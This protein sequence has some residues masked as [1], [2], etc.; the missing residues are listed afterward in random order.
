MY[1]F[2]ITPDSNL[3]KNFISLQ[4]SLSAYILKIFGYNVFSISN[5]ISIDNGYEIK[6]ISG[7]NFIK[8]LGIFLNFFISY[9]GN[10]KRMIKYIFI[11][12]S[13]LFISQIF[14]I[15]TFVFC[16]R[17]F[18]QYWDFYHINSAF[19]IYYPFTLFLWNK[20]ASKIDK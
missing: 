18:P 15:I 4:V 2:I 8:H 5:V 16:I 10:F 3:E 20:Y 7:C 19:L 9:P 13:Y 17:F 12:F 11:C 6:V 1:E 14:R